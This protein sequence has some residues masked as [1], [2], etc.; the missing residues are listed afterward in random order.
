MRM[1][2][3]VAAL[4]LP[5]LVA[6]LTSFKDPFGTEDYA[7]PEDFRFVMLDGAPPADEWDMTA[8]PAAEPNLAQDARPEAVGG[9]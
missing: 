5:A 3:V 6:G 8:A 4:S 2:W 7:L 1:L 9:L